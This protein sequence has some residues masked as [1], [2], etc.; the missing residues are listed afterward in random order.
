MRHRYVVPG[1][2]AVLLVTM[3]ALAPVAAAQMGEEYYPPPRTDLAE[4]V[5][6]LFN[7]IFWI[8]I[9]VL[10][11]V[12]VLIVVAFVKFRGNEDIPE[13]ETRRG[14]HRLE[15]AWTAVPA[16]ILL[17]V[18]GLS[19]GTLFELDQVPG[20]DADFTV[21][22]DAQQFAW[23]TTYPSPAD[24]VDLRPSVNTLR[25]EEGATVQMDITAA[26]VIHSL[27][28]P[29]FAI[30]IDAVPGRVNH[31]WFDAPA[32]QEGGDNEFFLQCAEYCGAGHHAMQGSIQVFPEGEQNIPYGTVP[33]DRAVTFTLAEGNGTAEATVD[34]AEVTMDLGK[35]LHL[36]VVNPANNTGT[37]TF[38][39]PGFD[40]ESSTLQPGET[41]SFKL[42]LTET[43]TFEYGTP[44]GGLEG[45]LTV[46]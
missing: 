17:L 27:W 26:D 9:A 34:P 16:V 46:R 24:G 31:Q 2:S 20:D 35:G 1:L 25:V 5:Q 32:Y 15:I 42:L 38:A 8:G 18:G 39:I 41:W 6:G 11:F 21:N 43:G 7:L 23:V 36:T 22:V 4:Q 40:V 37:H 44:E 14:N 29:S 12:E 30:K 3:L 33:R 45:T 28:V 19:A 10:V 13:H